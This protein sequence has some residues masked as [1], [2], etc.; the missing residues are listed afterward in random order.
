[1]YSRILVPIDGSEAAERGLDEAVALAQRLGS[2]LRILHVGD[3]RMLGAAACAYAPPEQLV[4]DWRIAGERLVPAAL[5]RAR[6][7]GVKAEGAMRCDPACSVHELI[8]EEARMF[9]AEL[10][11]MGTHGRDGLPRLLLGSDAECVLR[12]SPIP[13]LLVRCP[14]QTAQTSQAAGMDRP[15]TLTRP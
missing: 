14:A 7:L 13:V 6:V 15:A 3:S 9:D 5:E 4:D 8:L 10:I 11:I 1:M 2:T 12:A